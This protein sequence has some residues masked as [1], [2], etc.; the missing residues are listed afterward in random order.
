ML[1]VGMVHRIGHFATVGAVGNFA[2]NGSDRSG[3]FDVAVRPLGDWLT[4]FADAELPRGISATDAP[5][6]AGLLFE[7]IP[8][9]E[10]SSRYFSTEQYNIAIGFKFYGFWLTGSPQYSSSNERTSTTYDVRF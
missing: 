1:Q 5:W 2:I 6:S 8:G 3:L 10:V 4:V 7:A 9:L